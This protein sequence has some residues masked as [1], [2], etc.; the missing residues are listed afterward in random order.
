[1]AQAIVDH[2]IA[3]YYRDRSGFAATAGADVSLPPQL[4]LYD[5]EDA[6]RKYRAADGMLE[7]TLP[8]N[9]EPLIPPANP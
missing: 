3:D 7:L 6:A 8:P 9:A 4:R 1:M 2:G 5:A